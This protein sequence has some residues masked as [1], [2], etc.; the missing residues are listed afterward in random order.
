MCFSPP[1]EEGV[2]CILYLHSRVAGP[3]KGKL[4]IRSKKYVE[5]RRII[6]TNNT[7]IFCFLVIFPDVFFLREEDDRLTTRLKA[8][9]MSLLISIDETAQLLTKS[10]SGRSVFEVEETLS[11]LLVQ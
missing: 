4:E 6:R 11:P 8:E 1:G 10:A 3:R 2:V 5:E 7:R 9:G